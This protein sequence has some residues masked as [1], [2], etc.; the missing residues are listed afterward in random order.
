[1]A[2]HSSILAWKLPWTEEPSGL[3]SMG[4]QKVAGLANTMGSWAG[5][6]TELQDYKLQLFSTL[7]GLLFSH[8]QS[9]QELLS[10]CGSHTCHWKHGTLIR[11]RAGGRAWATL[12]KLYWNLQDCKGIVMGA[13][14]K[15]TQ[16]M[17][18][19]KNS[20]FHV[21]TE[22][23]ENIVHGL[24]ALAEETSRQNAERTNWFISV[25]GWIEDE[26]EKELFCIPLESKGNASYLKLVRLENET[27]SFPTSAAAAKSLQSCPTLCDPIDGSPP[28]SSVPG[29]L[30]ARTL[31][32]VAISFSNEWKW[33]LK[34][35]SLSPVWLLATP[36]TTAYQAPPSMGFSRQEHWEGC[37]CRLLPT[38]T[39]PKKFSREIR[40]WG[41]EGTW[42]QGSNPG[43]CL[44]E[45]AFRSRSDQKCRHKKLS[46][47][48]RCISG[49]TDRASWLDNMLLR[50]SEGVSLSNLHVDQRVCVLGRNVWERCGFCLME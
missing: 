41:R 47:D 6:S 31:E 5:Q 34:V 9:I 38:A 4:P 26:I 19:Q 14:G 12:K 50:I 13:W 42:W 30:Q 27:F 17:Y 10:T 22:K 18:W 48:L 28:G 37:H 33:K 23:T 35:K 25:E 45:V 2:N 29:I 49:Y 3:Q 32:W 36:W 11:N 16:L 21:I 44:W 20:V 8:R 39:A 1:M 40:T 43:Y 15:G 24:I 7:Q 46:S